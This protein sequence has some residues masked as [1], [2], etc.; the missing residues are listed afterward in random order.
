MCLSV[1]RGY[2]DH[3]PFTTAVT[4]EW[5]TSGTSAE[6]G[7][8]AARRGRRGEKELQ[9]GLVASEDG[10]PPEAEAMILPLTLDEAF[11]VDSA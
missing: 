6:G 5:R 4:L 7:A 8:A 9:V 10:R 2:G 11:V 1:T 3:T